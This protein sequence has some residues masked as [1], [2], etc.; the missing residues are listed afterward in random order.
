MTNQK[1]RIKAMEKNVA[2][3][4]IAEKLGITNTYFSSK[5]RLELPEDETTRILKIIEELAT[6]K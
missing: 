1:I 2:H 5:L 3:W 6:E 4:Q